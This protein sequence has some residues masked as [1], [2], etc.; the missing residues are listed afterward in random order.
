M[1]ELLL[2]VEGKGLHVVERKGTGALRTVLNMVLRTVVHVFV[3]P[4]TTSAL[5]QKRT[6][7][8]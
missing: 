7:G 1:G 8:M 4:N 6:G 2:G 5:N 3:E